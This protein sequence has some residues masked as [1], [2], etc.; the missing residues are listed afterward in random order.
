L[1]EERELIARREKRFLRVPDRI[2]L[3]L[4]WPHRFPLNVHAGEMHPGR[5][6]RICAVPITGRS[7]QHASFQLHFFS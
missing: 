6:M 1:R 4:G 7:H 5:A 2:P 3:S